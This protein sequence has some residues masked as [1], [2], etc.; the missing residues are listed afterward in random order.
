MTDCSELK[1]LA[2]AAIQR[3]GELP[4]AYEP[5]GDTGEYGVGVLQDDQQRYMSGRQDRGAML[6]VEPVA[7]DVHRKEYAAYIAAANPVAILALIAEV[8]QL[9]PDAERYRF[10]KLDE[11]MALVEDLAYNVSDIEWDAEIDAVMSKEASDG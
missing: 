4:W 8:E 5:H 9:R 7:T 2:E 10:I 1:R 6:V 3:S 11:Q